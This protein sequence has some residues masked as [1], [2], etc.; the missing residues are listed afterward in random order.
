LLEAGVKITEEQKKEI[1]MG[2]LNSRSY[3][4]TGG[5][6]K[7]DANG[8]RYTR[9]MMW[10]LTQNNGGIVHES[11]KPDTTFLVQADPDSQ[12]SKTKKA[13]KMGVGILS[14]EDFFKSLE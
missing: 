12:S 5:I 14:E 3:C 6:N 8:I 1:A 7:V 10:E 11:V 13:L 2:K 9:A 4:F